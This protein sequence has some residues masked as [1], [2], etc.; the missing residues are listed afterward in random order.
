MEG[1]DQELEEGKRCALCAE[2]AGK[3]EPGP[4]GCSCQSDS[5][6][7]S[8][9]SAL[10]SDKVRLLPSVDAHRV[11]G[12]TV[13]VWTGAAPSC[14]EGGGGAVGAAA[15]SPGAAVGQ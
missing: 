3:E 5:S 14:S 15:A 6:A 7:S 9:D 13:S 1:A 4:K 11:P 12:L 10:S 2:G 8:E